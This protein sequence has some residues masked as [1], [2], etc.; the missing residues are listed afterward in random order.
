MAR[1]RT[2]VISRNTTHGCA[3]T[4]VPYLNKLGQIAEIPMM[5]DANEHNR[6]HVTRQRGSM[7]D[8]EKRA[9]KR[10]SGGKTEMGEKD[11]GEY[12]PLGLV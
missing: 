12:S 2:D 5:C 6:R 3:D 8:K 1:A 11:G 10:E 7:M 9:R 4:K